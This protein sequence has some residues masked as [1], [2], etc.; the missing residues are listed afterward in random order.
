MDR[1]L[2][3]QSQLGRFIHVVLFAASFTAFWTFHVWTSRRKRSATRQ[4]N[5]MLSAAFIFYKLQ[6]T[7]TES[8]Y[9]IV[10]SLPTNSS[11]GLLRTV[12][13]MHVNK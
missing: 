6:W 8:R 4:G 7:S 13:I 2:D 10:V 3:V 5:A 11:N 9:V 12:C 1:Q